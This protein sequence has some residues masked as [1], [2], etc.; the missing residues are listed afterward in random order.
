MRIKAQ[1]AKNFIN[2]DKNIIIKNSVEHPT[3]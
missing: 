3:I 1:I 2:I